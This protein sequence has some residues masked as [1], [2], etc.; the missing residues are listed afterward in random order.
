MTTRAF[1]L[2]TRTLIAATCWGCGKF[3]PGSM[4]G[5]HVR[6]HRDRSAFIDRRCSNCRWAA[7]VRRNME[8]EVEYDG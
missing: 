5:R 6:N 2:G 4:F 8:G 1:E 7:K 3:L